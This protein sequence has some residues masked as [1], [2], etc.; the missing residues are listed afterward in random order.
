MQTV[1]EFIESDEYKSMIDDILSSPVL[2]VSRREHARNEMLHYMIQ[3]VSKE[4]GAASED[5]A[6]DLWEDYKI[7]HGISIDV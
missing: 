4:C 1:E 3:Q 6:L 5:E 2:A 7:R